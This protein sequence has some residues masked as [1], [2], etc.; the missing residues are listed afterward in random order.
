MIIDELL[1]ARNMSRYQLSKLSGVPQATLSDI[2]S[3]KASLEKCAAGTVYRI[4]GALGTTVETLL[5]L[6][7]EEREESRDGRS[8][9]DTFK[10]NVCHMVKDNGDLNYIIT[11]LEQDTVHALY[12]KGWYR[13]CLYVLAMLDYLCRVNDLPLCANYDDLRC[14]R[15][16][17][18]NYPRSV[19]LHAAVMQDESIKE[20]ACRNAIPE[21]MRAN[22]VEGEVWNIA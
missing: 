15:L 4:A 16:A 20:E 5:T 11:T 18:P 1:T 10:S 8:D 7:R 22:I 2:C 19:L 3:G 12:D 14:Q 17:E 6:D 9:F 21:F 13:E